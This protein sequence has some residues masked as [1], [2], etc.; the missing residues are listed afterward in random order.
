MRR[1]MICASAGPNAT[2][3]LGLFHLQ[4]LLHR[5]DRPFEMVYTPALRRQ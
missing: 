2:G 1:P 3:R 5:V 4:R